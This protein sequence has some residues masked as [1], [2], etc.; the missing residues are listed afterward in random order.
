M[1]NLL[2]PSSVYNLE[3]CSGR[4]PAYQ[5]L[6]P[7][8]VSRNCSCSLHSCFWL[9]A[10][11]SLLR[12]GEERKTGNSLALRLLPQNCFVFACRNEREESMKLVR[13]HRRERNAGGSV[14]PESG[15]VYGIER[16]GRSRVQL[17]RFV[18]VYMHPGKHFV[19]PGDTFPGWFALC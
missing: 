1:S 11:S 15:V 7:R 9:A 5:A 4:K 6:L 14:L 10:L 8:D 18:S 12:F 16:G 13:P 17:L 19:S 3:T 2:E